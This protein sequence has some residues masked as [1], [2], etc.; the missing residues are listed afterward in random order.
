MAAV[1]S[2]YILAWMIVHMMHGSVLNRYGSNTTTP[3]HAY[4]AA[5]LF[6]CHCYN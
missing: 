5:A 1:A 2:F 4:V 6:Y 3:V